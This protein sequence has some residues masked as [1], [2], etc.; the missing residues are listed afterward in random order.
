MSHIDET[1]KT[2]EETNIWQ[3]WRPFEPY[4]EFQECACPPKRLSS[5]YSEQQATQLPQMPLVALI[6]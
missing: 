3:P 6:L 5:D 2:T 1:Q 4:R